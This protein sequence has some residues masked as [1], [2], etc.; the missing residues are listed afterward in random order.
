[1]L[2]RESGARPVVV[3]NKSDL[4]ADAEEV[5]I[6]TA[7]LGARVVTTSALDGRGLTALEAHMTPCQTAGLTGSSGV[8]K[9]TLLNR[10]LGSERQRVQDGRGSDS[11]GRHT[12]VRRELFLAP[13]GWLIVDTP[14][15]RELQLW[16]GAESVDLAFADI[17]D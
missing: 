17:A 4:R 5:A 1:L 13:N 10:L 16:A 3:L 8:G 12:T 2:A 7:A 14:G 6:L 11:R 15:L 9:S